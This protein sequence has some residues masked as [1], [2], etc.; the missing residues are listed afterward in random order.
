MKTG[1]EKAI[2]A[3]GSLTELATKLHATPQTVWNWKHR[4]EVPVERCPDIE[5][6]TRELGKPVLCEH[7]RPDVDWA[8]LRQPVK[9]AA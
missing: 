4:G 1:I 8:V 6:V 5:R 7:L 2:E 3:A 9:A